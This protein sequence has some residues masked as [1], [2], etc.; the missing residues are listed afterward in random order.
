MYNKYNVSNVGQLNEGICQILSW[1]LI[2]RTEK[3]SK[4]D[5]EINSQS[6]E[7]R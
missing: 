4:D 1:G 6:I 2:L 5:F 3:L 7:I